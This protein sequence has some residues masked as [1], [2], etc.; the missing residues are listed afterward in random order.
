MNMTFRSTFPCVKSL[1]LTVSTARIM[2]FPKKGGCYCF[3]PTRS[4]ETAPARLN[5]RRAGAGKSRAN[6][7]PTTRRAR[8]TPIS[9]SIASSRKSSVR[10]QLRGGIDARGEATEPH[11]TRMDSYGFAPSAAFSGIDLW[12]R[13]HEAGFRGR[14]YHALRSACAAP[15]L[16]LSSSCLNPIQ[17]ARGRDT[18]RPQ[19]ARHTQA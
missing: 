1:S 16:G 9:R 12:L 11:E 10:K 18:R 3:S 4:R 15:S 17:T 6:R 2:F 14:A 19:S 13:R 5:W 8:S 7:P